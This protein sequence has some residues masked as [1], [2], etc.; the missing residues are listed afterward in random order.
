MNGN[1][2]INFNGQQVAL[3]FGFPQ[4]KQWGLFLAEDLINSATGKGLFFEQEGITTWGY[5]H[6]VYSAYLNACMVRKERPV[7]TFE[8]FSDWVDAS[9]NTDEFQKELQE[10]ITEWEASEY[11]KS[12]ANQ[13]KKNTDQM[14]TDWEKQETPKSSSKKSK[15]RSTQTESDM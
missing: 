14:L 12:W 1:V 15:P 8:N 13:L 6:L 7:L 2:T 11:T 4:T 10:V 9:V 5:A 3:K